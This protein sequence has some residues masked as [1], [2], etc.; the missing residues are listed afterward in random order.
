[1]KNFN[2]SF[3]IAAI[4]IIAASVHAQPPDTLWTRTFGG[5]ENDFCWSVE[6]TSDGGF[7][8]GG[9]TLS[10]GAFQ[11]DM[12]LV[13][14]DAQGSQEWFKIIGGLGQDHCNSVQQTSDGG[15]ILGGGTSSFG[16]DLGD[17]YLIKT[18][19][20]GDTVWTQAFG[21]DELFEN[22][23]SVSQTA[24]GGYIA[25]GDR[26]DTL[27]KESEI[28]LVKVDALGNLE[29]ELTFSMSTG[30]FCKSVQQTADGGYVLGGTTDAFGAN[31][32]EMYLL[33]ID[34]LGNQE[35]V[36]TYGGA[37]PDLCK[38]IQQTTDGGFILGGHTLPL[39][40]RSSDLY[41][42]KTDPL[43]NAEW[44]RTYGDYACCEYLNSLQQT[45]DGGYILAGDCVADTITFYQIN[46]VKIDDQG[47]I[48]WEQTFGSDRYD[49]C[50]SV[51]QTTDGNY[52]LAG[53]T[54]SYGV[55]MY[56]M[57]LVKLQAGAATRHL[58]A[59]PGPQ[60]QPIQVPTNSM[61]EGTFPGGYWSFPYETDEWG[62]WVEGGY[63]DQGWWIEVCIWIGPFQFTWGWSS[64]GGG[65][66]GGG[67]AGWTPIT[68]ASFYAEADASL[69]TIYWT[70]ASEI[71]N[72]HFVVYRSTN[73]ESGFVSI[74]EIPARGGWENTLY[75][76]TDTEIQTGI[77]HY[78]MISDVSIS[79]VETLHPNVISATP[80]AEAYLMVQNYPN[81]FNQ[82]TT[83]RFSIPTPSEV[84]LDIYDTAGR[85][86]CTL[87]SDLMEA[88]QHEIVWNAADGAGNVLPSGVYV[89]KLTAGEASFSRKMV[90]MK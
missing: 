23:T 88:G 14:T 52:I 78:Y 9:T 28:Y 57:Y 86:V 17:F 42:V 35:W 71:D 85:L 46:V 76:Y 74:A 29:W 1:M 58:D 70:T 38:A 68:L 4:F 79:G 26:L 72:H 10:F 73:A 84:R 12:Y 65:G 69:V 41:V 8:L 5:F 2:A 16:V 27:T 56:D 66:G 51:Q 34:H 33:K 24:D 20:N 81:P 53:S 44:E 62:I 25:G 6:Q 82:G 49:E 60:N 43:G 54:D 77:T 67:G 61:W 87:V 89:P 13:K 50:Y 45:T 48:E 63:G 7:I 11:E 39:E 3:V 75:S 36:R 18:D 59:A 19:A 55:G 30:D 83:I 40:G 47:N 22:C 21:E 90:I 37:Y 15:Y 32:G 31:H 64:G 80:L